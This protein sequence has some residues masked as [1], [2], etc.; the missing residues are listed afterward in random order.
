MHAV[1]LSTNGDTTTILSTPLEVQGYGCGVFELDGKVIVPKRLLKT[2]KPQQPAE[3]EEDVNNGSQ[4]IPVDEGYTDN[5]YLCSDIVE[6]S[7]VGSIKMSVLRYL[8]RKNGIPTEINNVIW[9]QV[10]RPSISSIRLYIADETENIIITQ[11]Y[12]EVHTSIYSCISDSVQKWKSHFQSM[13]EGTIPL[14]DI[15]IIN[16]KGHGLGT[17]NKGKALYKILSGGQT[18]TNTTTETVTTPANQGFAMAEA[19]IGNS[20]KLNRSQPVKKRSV[21]RVIKAK[22][23]PVKHKKV[24]KHQRRNISKKKTNKAPT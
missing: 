16:Q 7:D 17:T 20:N 2:N 13:A 18:P 22:K 24:S 11:K 8:K 15:Y 21:G 19:R 3:E 1:H 23:N 5:L 6:E 9:L 4:V 12:I 14:D 10:M